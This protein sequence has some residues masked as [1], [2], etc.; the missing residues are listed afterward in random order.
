MLA[1]NIEAKLFPLGLNLLDDLSYFR[2]LVKEG[3][4]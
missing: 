2:L 3:L 4:V 1:V